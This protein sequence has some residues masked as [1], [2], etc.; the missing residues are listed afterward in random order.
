MKLKWILMLLFAAGS[1]RAADTPHLGYVYP[2]GGQQGTSFE[3]MLGGQYL[4]GSTNIVI[5]GEGVQ[6]AVG[7]YSV[8]Y[9]RR[10]L[11]RIYSQLKNLSAGLEDKTDKERERIEKRIA[12][13]NAQ[14][15]VLELPE[16]IDPMNQKAVKQALGNPKKEQFNP[17]IAERI[18]A[19]VTIAENA[20]PGERELRVYTADGLSNPLFF[21]VGSLVEE[22]ETEPN[23][24]HM[25]PELQ[26]I[27]LPSI[28]NGQVAPGDIDHFRFEADLGDAIVV[29]VAARRIIPYLADAVPGWF[30]AVVALYDEDGNEVAYD[31][32]YKFHPD[33]VLFFKVPEAGTYTLSIRDAIYRGREDFVYRIAIGELPFITGIFPLGGRQGDPVNIAL[34]GWNLP[35]TRINGKLPAAGGT[36][37]HISVLKDGYR[38][39][40]MPFAIDDLPEAQESEPNNSTLQA[41]PVPLPA[42]INGRI[43]A[44]GDRDVYSFYGEKGT[45]VSIGVMA[46]R[47]NSPLDSIISLS[48]PGLQVP[49]R[50]DDYMRKDSA[51]LHLGAGLITHHADAYLLQELPETGTYFVEIGDTQ[52]KGGRDYAYRLRM[53]PAQP[54]FSLRMEP[55]GLQIAPG[56]TAVLSVRSTRREGFEGSIALRAAHL[57]EGFRVSPSTI[58]AGS[59]TALMTITAPREIVSGT[60]SPEIIGTAEINGGPVQHA[61][62]PVDN[63][64]QA[65]LYRHLVPARELV[66]SPTTDAA[67][68]AI[69]A[70]ASKSDAFSLPLGRETRIPL[71]GF[72]HTLRRGNNVSIDHPPEGLS[73]I[74]GWIGRD[75]K[76]APEKGTAWG[77][78]TLKAEAPLEVGDELTLIPVVIQKSGKEETR[79]PGPAI[80]IIVI[81]AE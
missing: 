61:A 63:Q 34:D 26:A 72:V 41:R 71:K 19:T 37:R 4:Q 68:V 10:Q 75:K 29:N 27:P 81:A 60:L 50:N 74:K 69:E 25:S 16:G 20:P 31:D 78:I 49:V 5:S 6:V 57:P 39:N 43:Q 54:D 44:S 79:Y 7:R 76:I 40:Q 28:I 45:T 58:P 22:M 56:G 42:I 23:D 65:F 64:M 1:A 3:I 73:V 8:K 66:L 80:R 53:A 59:D 14:L 33:P 13:F 2:A 12:L 36:S 18:R 46:R 62:V 52:A 15:A 11:G 48:G 35:K 32:D 67:P 70:R 38:S 77:S 24:D 55:S 30:Q 17:Q 21:D 51:H 47:L 9:E